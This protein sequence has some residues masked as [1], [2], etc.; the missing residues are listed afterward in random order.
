MGVAGCVPREPSAC[1]RMRQPRRALIRG[2]KSERARDLGLPGPG[3][4]C[5][6]RSALLEEGAKG[7]SGGQF[8]ARGGR[9]WDLLEDGNRRRGTPASCPRSISRRGGMGKGTSPAGFEG[10]LS[11]PKAEALFADVGAGGVARALANGRRGLLGGAG[12]EVFLAFHAGRGC[13][14]GGRPL[15]PALSVHSPSSVC[16]RFSM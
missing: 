10:A 1:S 12:K 6:P 5:A 7:R 14:G 9:R 11:F 15:Q 16:L 4:V 8:V 3:H 2:V 13:W